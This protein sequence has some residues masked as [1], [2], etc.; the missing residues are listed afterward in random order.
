MLSQV[1]GSVKALPKA[2]PAVACDSGN[3][4]ASRKFYLS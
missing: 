4:R 1:L 2:V 3:C